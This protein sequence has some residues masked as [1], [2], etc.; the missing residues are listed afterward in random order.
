MNT[1]LSIAITAVPTVLWLRQL[2]RSN[3]V[4][5][6]NAELTAEAK[7]LRATCASFT[8]RDKTLCDQNEKLKA[9]ITDRDQTKQRMEAQ[10]KGEIKTLQAEVDKL[11]A[12]STVVPKREPFVEVRKEEPRIGSMGS[13][14]RKSTK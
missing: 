11:K 1:L 13:N 10:F 14:D 9:Q 4:A 8:A 3:T 2:K 6:D 12:A 5:S 7:E